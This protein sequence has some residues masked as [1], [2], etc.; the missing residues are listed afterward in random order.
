MKASE[1]L[2]SVLCN[3]DGQVSIKGCSKKD[4]NIICDAIQK[5]YDM[6]E[7]IENI[8]GHLENIK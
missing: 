8:I 6:E 7:A 3:P 2:L 1:M 4:A 5:V